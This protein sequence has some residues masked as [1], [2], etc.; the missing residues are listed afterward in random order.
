M[1]LRNRINKIISN[2]L[3]SCESATKIMSQ[4]EHEDLSL[5]S[6]WFL[7][8][9]LMTCDACRNFYKQVTLLNKGLNEMNKNLQ[10][11]KALFQLPDDIKNQLQKNLKNKMNE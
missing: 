4:M 5:K 6:K 2:F 9:H 1:S 3:L 11:G 7:K 10:K 8:M